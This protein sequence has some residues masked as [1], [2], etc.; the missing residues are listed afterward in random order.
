MGQVGVLP[1]PLLDEAGQGREHQGP[2]DALLVHQR[3]AGGRLT[4]G[5]DRLHGLPEDLP[6]ALP[7]GVAHPEVL[8][9]GPGAG[10]DV[11]GG[12]RDV[13]ADPAPDDDLGPPPHLDVV[14][15]A[16][17]PLGQVLGQRLAGLVEVVVG[18]EQGDAERWLRHD[19]SSSLAMRMIFL[20]NESTVS[21][22]GPP[23]TGEGA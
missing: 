7:L 6:P 15:G 12:I 10:H 5:R 14:D 3:Q 19:S 16:P 9:L 18:I 4:E 2:V 17:V 22:K 20:H 1:H 23:A 8:L 11:E 13:L 21:E